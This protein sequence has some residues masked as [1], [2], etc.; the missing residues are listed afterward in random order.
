MCYNHIQ[1]TDA[2]RQSA[3][4]TA[5]CRQHNSVTSLEYNWNGEGFQGDD[6]YTI[7]SSFADALSLTVKANDGT[8]DYTITL[9]PVNFMW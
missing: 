2:S 1:Y 8:T 7:D 6:T 5:R 4:V 9:E 3:T